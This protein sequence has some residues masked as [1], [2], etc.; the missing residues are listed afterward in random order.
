[1]STYTGLDMAPS[2]LR[3]SV[4]DG[5]GAVETNLPIYGIR[6]CRRHPDYDSATSWSDLMAFRQSEFSAT[7]DNG[8]EKTVDYVA[9]DE[10]TV[11]DW[12]REFFKVTGRKPEEDPSGGIAVA[13]PNHA[14]PDYRDKVLAGLST[15]KF[16]RVSLIW[17]PVAILLA[18]L[19][20]EAERGAAIEKYEGKRVVVLDLDGGRPELSQ[21]SI[22]RH[23]V[24]RDWIIPYR[25]MP[26]RGSVLVDDA[27]EDACYCAALGGLKE[28][29]Q[30]VAGQFFPILQ[31]AIE[32]GLG[33]GEV[34]IRKRGAWS[35]RKIELVEKLPQDIL[36]LLNPVFAGTHV[37]NDDIF[38]INGWVARRY[39]SQ[40]SGPFELRCGR[41]DVV[42]ED[43]VS[44]GAAIFAERLAKGD[45]T[46][47]DTI[48]DYH[49]WDSREA[50]WVRMFDRE[51]FVEP[52]RECR[53]PADGE[54]ERRL[55]IEKF[56]NNVSFYVRETTSPEFARRIKT[57]FSESL[58]MDVQVRLSAVVSPE[59]GSA[60]F[61]LRMCD[62][63][64]PPIFVSGKKTSRSIVLRWTLMANETVTVQPINEHMGVLEP[65]PVLGRIYDGEDNVRLVETYVTDRNG[66]AHLALWQKY[67]RRFQPKAGNGIA[68]RVG[69]HCRPKE[70]T[71]GMFGTKYVFNARIDKV[72][73]DY[74][75]L[76]AKE[77]PFLK[78]DGMK[79][80]NYCHSCATDEYKDLIRKALLKGE[81]PDYNF[82]FY[83]AA[84]YVLG[85]QAEDV[86]ILLKYLK[87]K[88]GL[89]SERC[90]LWWAFFR[91]LCWHPEC[92][93][94]AK[95]LGLLEDCLSL[96][97]SKDA[98]IATTDRFASNDKKFL[99]L[100]ILYALR[101]RETGVDLSNGIKAKLIALLQTGLLRSIPFPSTMVANMKACAVGDT[102]SDYVVR[103]IKYED[104][105]RDREL[106]AAMGGV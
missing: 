31:E 44:Q 72:S 16:G 100:A 45:P 26:I 4:G 41:V 42:S 22:G 62:D 61:S 90:K 21:L 11:S 46:F 58:K 68:D 97:C 93:L 80:Q 35:P 101:I 13:V 40:I 33:C 60:E 24:R 81:A 32:N 36:K 27:F 47:Y 96:I 66:A 63:D 3:W 54:S 53:Y 20:K 82:N 7:F 91:M 105:L 76:C 92:G 86:S 71:R 104:T 51:Q 49:F 12:L 52:G 18:W 85:D 79:Y 67:Q 29:K 5:S 28:Y 88:T 10:E 30:I 1:M 87:A 70:P 69:Y 19:S 50:A 98:A 102:L 77:F 103:F 38:L 106:G 37:K 17:R 94:R 6:G 74:A 9:S 83:Y 39:R 48:P 84:G 25:P 15:V 43:S 57:N 73:H 65:Q 59:K 99:P 2:A 95:D 64:M 23:R 14:T 78:S 89:R 56:N 55:S 75:I 34:W 8:V